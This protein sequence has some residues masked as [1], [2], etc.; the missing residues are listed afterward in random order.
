VARL[1]GAVI[2]LALVAAVAPAAAEPASP[3]AAEPAPV[4]TGERLRAANA[5]ALAGEWPRVL[6]LVDPLFHAPDRAPELASAQ[7]GEA[8]RL[9]GIA[10]FFAQGR[11]DAEAHFVAYL[12]LDPEA[13]LDPALSPP[14]VVAFFNDVASRHAA[15]LRARVRF[16]HYLSLNFLPPAGQFQNGE[17][18]KGFVLGGVLVGLLAT[19]LTTYGLLHRWCDQ[20]TGP[21]G[22]GL[23]CDN[24]HGDHT[25]AASILRPVNL[26]SGIAFIAAYVYGV[27]DG[28]RGYRRRSREMALEPYV[29]TTSDRKLFGI[30]ASF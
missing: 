2:C 11:A 23:D 1:A 26:A 13:R 6:A 22:G 5:A 8:H 3:P 21:G 17:W 10:A 29:A 27:Y 7:L 9:A 16:R 24:G 30:Q 20:T 19:N 4:T 28:V 12:H 25:R 14:D 18:T 15:E